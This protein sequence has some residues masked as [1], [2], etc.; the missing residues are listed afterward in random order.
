MRER[1]ARL[2]ALLTGAAVLLLA[3][4][5][6][7][8]QNRTRPPP[9]MAEP[10]P[11]VVANGVRAANEVQAA[12]AGRSVFDEQRC[13]RCHSI[14]GQGNPRSPLD[15][16]GSR[17]SREEIRQWIVA[18]DAIKDDLSPRALSAKQTYAALP[19]A[20]LDALVDYLQ[21]LRE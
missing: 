1:W 10:P 6:A 9:A 13:A 21:G 20:Q 3:V 5:F 4:G 11:V 14:A 7:L 2:L 18:D 8:V 15:G 19:A 12:V 16:V 17:L